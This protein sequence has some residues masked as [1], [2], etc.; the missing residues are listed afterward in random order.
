MLEQKMPI[1]ETERLILRPFTKDDTE[2]YFDVYW[3]IAEG[4]DMEQFTPNARPNIDDIRE[5]NEYYLNFANY[6]FL[7]PFGRWMVVL[8][9]EQQN[10]GTCLLIPHLFTPEEVTLCAEPERHRPQFGAFEILIGWAIIRSY[11]G[12]GYATEAARELIVYGFH[13]VKLHR[14]VSWTDPENT[15]SLNVMRKVGMQIVS[16]LHSSRVISMVEGDYGMKI[17]ESQS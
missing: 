2:S 7:R 9:S 8:K 5:E 3:Q 13:T 14:I 6:G 17:D 4:L 12:Y 11:R 1:L 10:I 15:A 16:P